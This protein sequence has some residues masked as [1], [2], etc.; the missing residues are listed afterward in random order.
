MALAECTPFVKLVLKQIDDLLV[1]ILNAAAIRSF[2]LA[3]M[4]GDS[5]FTALVEPSVIPLILAAN[6]AVGVDHG[7]KCEES[8]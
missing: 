2:F 7:N 5:G 4:N 3:I 8:S 1:K 6:A